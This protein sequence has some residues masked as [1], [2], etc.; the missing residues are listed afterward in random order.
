MFCRI[1]F[2]SNHFN[3]NR[4]RH[5]FV[6]VTFG[7]VSICDICD[8]MW[9][10]L[11]R[12]KN[13]ENPER[14]TEVTNSKL[15]H[16]L[17]VT[18]VIHWVWLSPLLWNLPWNSFENEAFSTKTNN[19][20]VEPFKNSLQGLFKYQSRNARTN[21]L[22]FSILEMVLAGSDCLHVIFDGFGYFFRDL[23][24]FRNAPPRKFARL[25]KILWK[26]GKYWKRISSE[27]QVAGLYDAGR[28]WFFGA[29]V[30]K[31]FPKRKKFSKHK[32]RVYLYCGFF[33][34]VGML[35]HS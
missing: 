15:W 32:S 10:I 35:P 22:L 11:F 3:Q 29:L 26:F 2:I 8:K 33:F 17:T 7:F 13:W 27:F 23:H 4:N 24:A 28:D 30:L 31:R 34:W 14:V 19:P 6:P 9:P 18:N 12:Y 16:I 21:S 25:S 5:R 20:H 1:P